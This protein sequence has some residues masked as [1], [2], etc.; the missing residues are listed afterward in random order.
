M[1]TY[2]YTDS[3]NTV[4]HIID[5]D[6]ISRSSCLASIIDPSETII[7]ADPPTSDQIISSLINAVQKHLDETAKTRGYD[8]I[9]SACT[10]ATDTNPT[11]SA[12][13]QACVSWRSAVWA[14]CYQIMAEVMAGTRPTPTESE[15]I[16]LLPVI[17]WP[18]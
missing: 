13:G 15:L 4:V 10:Y 14:K 11:F 3:T 8:G 16:A 12:E 7:P 18:T 17:I 5:E 9:L 6:G 1:K 2:K